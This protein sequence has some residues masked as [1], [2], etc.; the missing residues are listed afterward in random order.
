MNGID[1]LPTKNCMNSATFM[2]R[3]ALKPTYNTR[4]RGQC[5]SCNY[6]SDIDNPVSQPCPF[7]SE[8][9]AMRRKAEVL[10]YKNNANFNGHLTKAQKYSL[11]A[12]RKGP[13]QK[14]YGT[15]TQTYTNPN[16][17]EHKSTNPNNLPIKL[18]YNNLRQMPS[19]F[20]PE[21]RKNCPIVKS[22]T[23]ASGVPG[24]EMQLFMDEN[25]PLTDYIIRRNYSGNHSRSDFVF[26]PKVVTNPSGDIKTTL[27]ISSKETY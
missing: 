23:H 27:F 18:A 4:A 3:F 7:T 13:N 16:T 5:I 15:Q 10:Q 12:R 8:Q 2:R 20:T 17:L 9:L 26:V 24:P 6:T 25:V 22:S 1:G 21:H 14:T 19:S 11:I